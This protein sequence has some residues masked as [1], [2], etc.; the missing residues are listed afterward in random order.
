MSCYTAIYF[1]LVCIVHY[2]SIFHPHEVINM[3]EAKERN[4]KHD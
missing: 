4:T 2:T 3:Y 1:R